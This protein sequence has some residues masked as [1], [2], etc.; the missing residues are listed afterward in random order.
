MARPLRTRPTSGI[1]PFA[2]HGPLP[3]RLLRGSHGYSGLLGPGGSGRTGI[4]GYNLVGEAAPE[5]L[6]VEPDAWEGM[7]DLVPL[8]VD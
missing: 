8:V 2:T 3:T 6:A 4:G 7:P 1:T 5:A